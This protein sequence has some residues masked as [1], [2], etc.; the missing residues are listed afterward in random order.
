MIAGATANATS[1]N[2]AVVWRLKADGG[3]GTLNGAR[4]LTFDGD[5]Q[6]DLDNGGNEV[7]KA[8]AVQPDG[9]IVVAGET[10]GGPL[11]TDAL[12]WRIDANGGESNLTN[13]ALD[14]TFD[15]DGVAALG[16]PGVFAQAE[17]L[18]LQPDHKILVAGTSKVGANPYNADV[19]R[20]LANGGSGAVNGALDPTFGTGGTTSVTQ[21]SG[22]G[23]TALVLQPD[24]RIIA[25]GAVFGEGLL[26]F[27]ALGDPFTVTVARAGTGA[28]AVGSSPPGIECGAACSSQ[29]DDGASV[30][31]TPKPVAGSGFAGWS[32]DC[33]GGASCALTMSADRTVTATFNAVPPPPPSASPHPPTLAAV[34][35]SHAVWREGTR[36]ASLSRAV[37]KRAP[38]GTTF[39]FTLDQ[40]ASVRFAFTQSVSGRRVKGK[41]VGQTRK[42]RHTSPCVRSVSRGTLVFAAHAGANKLAFQGRI[43][44]SKKL[45]LGR[46]TLVITAAT[47]SGQ[48]STAARLRFTIVK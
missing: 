5:G 1:V 2:D 18:Q 34:T 29:F 11:A 22:A 6:A 43:T 21:G 42:N 14:P 39:T 8:V 40:P 24:R 3:P 37:R 13:D 26:L 44:R 23:A 4:D 12:V 19:W 7:A 32:G 25:A 41:C 10:S 38:L 27:R 9:K 28:G 16:G 33:T 47:G 31:L 35:Q 45:P 46:Y 17:A 48:R 15:T 30:A 20:L 36:L